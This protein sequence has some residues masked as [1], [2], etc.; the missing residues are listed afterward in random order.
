MHVQGKQGLSHLHKKI[1]G[2]ILITVLAIVF[3]VSYGY[4]IFSQSNQTGNTVSN[5]P[6]PGPTAT[7]EPTSTPSPSEEPDESASVPKSSVPEFTLNFVGNS[8]DVP[9]TYSIDPYTGENVTHA[10]YH[11][12]NKY[13]EVRIR[14]QP[15]T[16]Y[17]IQENDHNRTI[18]FF[19]N[20]RVKGTFAENW[21]N[22]Y[23]G[24][25]GYL[26]EDY[27]SE[28]TVI[29][30]RANAKSGGQVDFQVEALIGYEHPMLSPHAIPVEKWV[31]TGEE[32]GW[33]NTQTITLP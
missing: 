18:N 24:S 23:G 4:S 31:I 3:T 20:I 22:L 10:G 12:E 8:Y 15:F 1:I 16:P 26:M 5:S 25:Y 33:S 32:S 29:P 14:N 2:I 13:I 21:T 6:S 7:P 9:V 30:Y 19:Y 17:W 27:G 28:Y 11:V